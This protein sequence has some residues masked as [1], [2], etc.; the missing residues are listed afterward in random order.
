M[1]KDSVNYLD[2]FAVVKKEVQL[3]KDS[4]SQVHNHPYR[5]VNQNEKGTWI[6]L[7]SKVNVHQSGPGG[8]FDE[9]VDKSFWVKVDE[10]HIIKDGT[11]TYS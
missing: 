11:I 10:C 1:K 9:V 4:I 8:S 3:P 2:K 6:C 5:I 7:Q